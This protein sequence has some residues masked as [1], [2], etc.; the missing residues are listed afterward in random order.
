MVDQYQQERRWERPFVTVSYE[1]GACAKSILTSL[2]EYLTRK[3]RRRTGIWQLFDGNL[4]EEVIN[5]HQLSSDVLPYLG[6]AA[7]EL[8]D[9]IEEVIGLHPSR[10]VLVHKMNKTILRLS[11]RGYVILVGRGANVVT[12]QMPRGVHVRLIGSVDRRVRYLMEYYKIGEGQAK[13]YII[14]EGRK[15]R[16]YYRKYFHQDINDPRLYDLIINTDKLSVQDIIGMIGALVFNAK[17]NSLHHRTFD[18][19]A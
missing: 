17:S 5:D 18:P 8:E 15:R 6:T 3:E 9:I 16:E 19:A 1:L 2:Q 7:S 13:Q 14:R 11:Q 10:H 4:L 12:G